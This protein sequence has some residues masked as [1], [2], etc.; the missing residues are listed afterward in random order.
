VVQIVALAFL[1]CWALI[2]HTFVIHFQQHE[3]SILLDVAAHVEI[4]TFPFQL[5]LY[6]T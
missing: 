6:N 1:G 5:A 4:D 3:Y 2:I